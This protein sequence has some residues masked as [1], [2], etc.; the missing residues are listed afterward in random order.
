[1]DAGRESLIFESETGGSSS[2]WFF[3]LPFFKSETHPENHFDM[4]IAKTLEQL[5]DKYYGEWEE[6]RDTLV[7]ELKTIHQELATSDP[8]RLQEFKFRVI[9]HYGGAYIP[10]VFWQQL[11]TFLNPAQQEDARTFLHEILKSFVD[12]DFEEPEKMKMKPLVVTYFTAEKEFE[13]NKLKTL[14]FE[15]SH[16]SVRDYFSTLEGF[17]TKNK[18]ATVMYRRK[19]K[20]LKDYF[21]DFKLLDQPLS[22]LEESLQN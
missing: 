14:V 5:E 8:D 20:M 12:S 3:F 4:D 11:A 2:L 15:K 19:F 6:S 1:L 7:G 22:Y 21:P 13:I 16:P 18:R 10:Y 9:N 17:I